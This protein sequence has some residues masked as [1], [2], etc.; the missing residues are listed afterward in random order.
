MAI[1]LNSI[2]MTSVTDQTLINGFLNLW[3]LIMAICGAL[4]VD[5]FGR[6]KLFLT[7]TLIMLV[8]YIIITALSATFANTGVKPAGTA[9]S[10]LRPSLDITQ[11]T[12]DS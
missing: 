12:H 9:V 5:R 3:N 11:L 8:S 7:S 4:L 6:K 2:G 1:I 10:N